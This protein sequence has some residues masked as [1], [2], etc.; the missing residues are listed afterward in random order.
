M[1]EKIL[2][3]TQLR[4]D[5]LVGNQ[6]AVRWR[7]CQGFWIKYFLAFG[8]AAMAKY[9]IQNPKGLTFTNPLGGLATFA[10]EVI[11]PT[12]LDDSKNKCCR[13]GGYLFKRVG[14]VGWQWLWHIRDSYTPYFSV[15]FAA[16]A[17]WTL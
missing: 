6:K 5:D 14:S 9:F 11:I 3:R 13:S 8:I 7:I 12:C 16:F 17:V 10:L 4:D 2:R 1:K 15:G